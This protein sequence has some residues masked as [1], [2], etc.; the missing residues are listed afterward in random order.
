D[1]RLSRFRW[2]VEGER[3][4]FTEALDRWHAEREASGDPLGADRRLAGEAVR[5]FLAAPGDHLRATLAVA[6]R[7]LFAERSPAVAGVLDLRLPLGLGLLAGS[8]ILLVRGARR[9]DPRPLALLA[10]PLALFLFHAGATEF[11]PR[12]GVPSLPLVWAAGVA[13]VLGLP[14][15]SGPRVQG[16]DEV[17]GE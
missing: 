12:F 7:G 15:R 8:V 13:A 10:L 5:G 6:W 2:R 1:S 11:L 14:D 16:V 4:Y 17:A 9:R 3:N